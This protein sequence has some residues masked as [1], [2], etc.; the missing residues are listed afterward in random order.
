MLEVGE[1]WEKWDPQTMRKRREFC[2]SQLLT[3]MRVLMLMVSAN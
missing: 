2:P 3:R 1:P